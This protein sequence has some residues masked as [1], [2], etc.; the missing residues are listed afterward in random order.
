MNDNVNQNGLE[1]VTCEVKNNEGMVSMD[2]LDS[3]NVENSVKTTYIATPVTKQVSESI[4][5]KTIRENYGFFGFV[6]I[7]YAMFYTF[8]LYKNDSGITVPL[9]EI[10]TFYY[11][12]LV[13]KKLGIQLKKD[14]IFYMASIVLLGISICL[15]DDFALIMMSKLGITILF[16]SFMLHQ[17]YNDSKWSL[18]KYLESIAGLLI[19]TIVAMFDP[20]TDAVRA[21]QSRQ[22][23]E[24]GKLIYILIGIAITI[25]LIFI[26]M[27]LLLSADRIFYDIFANLLEEL[28]VLNN[29]FTIIL[30][31]LF[32][33]VIFYSFINA[34]AKREIKEEVIDRRTQE[35]I[36]AI[37]CSVIISAVYIL[38]C[39]IQIVGLFF[40]QMKLPDGYT[41]AQYAREGFFQLL[42]VCGMN[43]V[44]VLCCMAFFR[45]SKVLKVL[46][47]II[48][49]CTY[50]MVA[51]SAYRMILYISVYQLTFMRIF[52]LWAL[53]VIAL[54]MF[55]IVVSIFKDSF[56]LFRY[57]MIVV[58]VLYIGLAFS[59]PD[60][61]VASYYVHSIKSDTYT[62]N[63]MV[64][65]EDR[66]DYGYYGDL[67]YITS[68]S[69]DAAPALAEYKIESTLITGYFENMKSKSKNMGIRS[70]NVSR[71]I[72]GKLAEEDL[73]E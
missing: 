29:L 69:A 34:V 20:F 67:Y 12:I 24:N 62:Q 44:I 63:Y 66:E 50:I 30:M 51:S 35:P 52:V 54:L 49:V 59:R 15:T 31:A 25:P 43:L 64:A 1:N 37:T 65:F 55:G 53:F 19:Y 70:F 7:I 10:G 72:A 36:I 71:Y 28:L 3:L 6:S 39:G 26:I 41:Y 27:A 42:F 17:F 48:S 45:E 2:K 18:G 23:K 13:I 21:I 40:G 5:R 33:Y 16:M 38:F 61:F 32:A 60:Y 46:L 68:L 9:L 47:T 58:T 73:Q 22:K 4:E 11:Y 57:S 14:T 8:C 56:P